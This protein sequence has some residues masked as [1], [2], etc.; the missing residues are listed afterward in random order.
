MARVNDEGFII[1]T[2]IPLA[3]GTK[4]YTS[5]PVAAQVQAVVNKQLTTEPSAQVDESANPQGNPV[6]ES[7]EMQGQ[8]GGTGHE[9]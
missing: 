6:D 7:T 4:L 8:T 1:E 5:A 9:D 3:P 2:G